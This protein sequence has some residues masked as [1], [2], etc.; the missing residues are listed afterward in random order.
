MGTP[1][2]LPTADLL[3]HLA[4]DCRASAR[5]RSRSGGFTNT[6]SSLYRS[7]L[8]RLASTTSTGDK[9]PRSYILLRSAAPKSEISADIDTFAH[10]DWTKRPCRTPKCPLIN[11]RSSV[12]QILTSFHK[13]L[14]KYVITVNP[15]W[16]AWIA[17]PCIV[18][19]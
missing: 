7:V 16:I 19:R 11:G 6:F 12:D 5:I 8:S 13:R 3:R 18:P 10:V 9:N 1:S 15:G 2:S 14:G 4:S 17:Q